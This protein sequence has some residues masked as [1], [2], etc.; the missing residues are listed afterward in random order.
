VQIG[1]GGFPRP[2]K[3]EPLGAISA[4]PYG[5]ALILPISYS[6]IAMMG[7]KGLTDA[8][9]IAILNANYMA[10]LLE[11]RLILSHLCICHICDHDIPCRLLIEV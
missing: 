5:S 6:Y 3:T 2:E 9:K 4:A 11:V 8:S 10:K 1:T 7:N